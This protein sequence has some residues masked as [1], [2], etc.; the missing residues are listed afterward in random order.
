MPVEAKKTGLIF[1]TKTYFWKIFKERYLSEHDLSITDKLFSACKFNVQVIFK[2]ILGADD[3]CLGD[4]QAWLSKSFSLSLLNALILYNNGIDPLLSCIVVC[5]TMSVYFVHLLVWCR[6]VSWRWSIPWSTWP[7][8]WPW[9]RNPAAW[10]VDSAST[11]RVFISATAW[12]TTKSWR[13]SSAWRMQTVKRNS[14]SVF[15]E[16]YVI[17]FQ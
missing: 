3:S 5:Y 8:Q 11:S 15:L 12:S 4:V 16:T 1:P 17:N 2:S 6:W 10:P 9:G 7:R 13:E 14:G